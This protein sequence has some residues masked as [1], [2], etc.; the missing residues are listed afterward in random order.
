[1]FIL[2][3]RKKRSWLFWLLLLLAGAM[4]WYMQLDERQKRFVQNIVKQIPY[5]PA[6]YSV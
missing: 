6:R 5:L 1:M 2:F 4:V 3:K